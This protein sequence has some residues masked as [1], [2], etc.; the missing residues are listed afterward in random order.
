MS[1]A[2]QNVIAAEDARYAAMLAGD[3]V[4]LERLLDKDLVYTHSDGSRDTF[5]TYLEK[6]SARH[7]VY[8]DVK[9]PPESVL[10]VGDCAILT[11]TMIADVTVAGQIRNLRNSYLAVYRMLDDS[12]RLLAYQP[13]PLR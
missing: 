6:V 2:R 1:T 4:T 8:R 11:G 13:T 5:A 7:F 3:A 12:W 10:I 9:A